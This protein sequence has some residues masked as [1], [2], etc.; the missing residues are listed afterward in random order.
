M[1]KLEFLEK[2]KNVEIDYH[3]D[4][5]ETYNVLYDLWMDYLYDTNDYSLEYVFSDF[6]SYELAEDIAKNELETSGLISLYY[7]LGNA[8]LT[9]NIFKI[10]GYGHLENI[11]KSDLEY[12]KQELI[13]NLNKEV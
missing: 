12:I 2:V 11:D 6:C 5:E 9:E 8:D 10:N 3:I 7:F 4:F 13:Y 1:N